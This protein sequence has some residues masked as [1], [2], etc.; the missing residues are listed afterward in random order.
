[1]LTEISKQIISC[2][3]TQKRTT[4]VSRRRHTTLLPSFVLLL[5]TATAEHGCCSNIGSRGHGTAA[6]ALVTDVFI[7]IR[8]RS[9]DTAAAALV[10]DVFIS[11][12]NSFDNAAALGIGVCN[13]IGN[14]SLKMRTPAV[15]F[16]FQQRQLHVH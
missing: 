8:S 14:R 1:M 11:I 16:F 10:T 9:C 3:E 7:S 12:R 5:F 13:N 15:F 6:A 2:Q 4:N